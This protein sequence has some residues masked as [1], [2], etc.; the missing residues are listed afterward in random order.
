MKYLVVDITRKHIVFTEYTE[1]NIYIR[2]CMY[3]RRS[4][5]KILQPSVSVGTDL[6]KP[7]VIIRYLQPFSVLSKFNVNTFASR[8]PRKNRPALNRFE[9][10]PYSI[11]HIRFSKSYAIYKKSKNFETGRQVSTRFVC[12]SASRLHSRSI[13]RIRGKFSAEF[14]ITVVGRYFS[15]CRQTE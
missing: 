2:V 4:K 8:K 7:V 10:S 15:F 3:V 12:W 9:S 1:V 11:Y 13:K 6:S 5:S 14:L